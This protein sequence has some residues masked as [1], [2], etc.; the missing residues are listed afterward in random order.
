MWHW[1][2]WNLVDT[3]RKLPCVIPARAMDGRRRDDITTV[4]AHVE[5]RP[6]QSNGIR[7][8]NFRPRVFEVVVPSSPAGE[9][10]RCIG[11]V[12]RPGSQRLERFVPA[13]AWVHVQNDDARNGAGRDPDIRLRPL[14]PPLL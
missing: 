5:P 11:Q 7:Y 9:D 8:L 3:T 10:H 6:E 4:A 14:P 12:A 2:D 1:R 13:V